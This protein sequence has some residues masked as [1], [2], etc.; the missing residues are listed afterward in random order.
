MKR[1]MEHSGETFFS[2]SYN[3]MESH[4]QNPAAVDVVSTDLPPFP[5]MVGYTLGSGIWSCDGMSNVSIYFCAG[6]YPPLGPGLPDIQKPTPPS[7][8]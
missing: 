1:S 3:C 8:F 6:M 7:V 4:E 5:A 2:K